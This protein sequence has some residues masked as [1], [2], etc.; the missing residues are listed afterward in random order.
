MNYFMRHV[1]ALNCWPDEPKEAIRFLNS[2]YPC[3]KFCLRRLMH[4]HG[5][6]RENQTQ[7]T[8]ETPNIETASG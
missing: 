3:R 8:Q 7:N 5:D 4:M 2:Y 1:T 6:V